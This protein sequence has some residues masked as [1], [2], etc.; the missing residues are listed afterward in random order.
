MVL[1][2][3][4]ETSELFFFFC[5]FF[6]F[7][8][9]LFSREKKG[10][11]ASEMRRKVS[12]SKTKQTSTTHATAA[13]DARCSTISSHVD[14]GAPFFLHKPPRTETTPRKPKQTQRQASIAA[15]V[16]AETLL[17][18]E[19]RARASGAMREKAR[20]VAWVHWESCESTV[21]FFFN[22]FRVFFGVFSLE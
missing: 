1:A 22:V 18:P 9:F 3:I 21:L 19:T 14:P 7:D 10:K 17:G 8:V 20:A 4:Q 12:R 16:A 13:E 5:S 6:F 15:S 2:R 11:R